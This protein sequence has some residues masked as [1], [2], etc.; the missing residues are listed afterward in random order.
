MYG[1]CF[2]VSS[3][4]ADEGKRK[5]LSYAN[6]EFDRLTGES[7]D[8]GTSVFS[9]SYNEEC[10]VDISISSEPPK[11]HYKLG[12]ETAE[13][14]SLLS[15]ASVP[16]QLSVVIEE[17]KT[18][19]KNSVPQN[20]VIVKSE[21]V[22]IECDSNA[23]LTFPRNDECAV[24][25][26][27]LLESKRPV[28]KSETDSG[29]DDCELYLKTYE[30][31]NDSKLNSSVFWERKRPGTEALVFSGTSGTEINM[32]TFSG[33]D[34]Q[35]S[36]NIKSRIDEHRFFYTENNGSGINPLSC[37]GINRPHRNLHVYGG[38][39]ESGISPS[40]Y[41]GPGINQSAYVGNS[42][43]GINSP[44]YTGNSGHG[45]NTASYPMYNRP[46]YTQPVCSGNNGLGINYLAFSGSDKSEIN[47]S[48]SGNNGVG[49]NS[50]T[51]SGSR[52]IMIP[53]TYCGNNG[54]AITPQTYSGNG[55]RVNL[56]SY[57]GNNGPGIN[58]QTYSGNNESGMNTVMYS[59]NS[60]PTINSSYCGSKGLYPVNTR[61][62]LNSPTY[63]GNNIS[64]I[65]SPSCS[66]NSG[67][68][69]NSPAYPGNNGPTVNSSAYSRNDGTGINSPT[70]SGNNG[71]G[72]NQMRFL[73]D[74]SF[75][76]SEV[77]QQYEILQSYCDDSESGTNNM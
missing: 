43:S 34:V 73:R 8:C 72:V 52:S 50:L 5:E 19:D 70:Y 7:N 41:S 9:D 44:A 33:N 20:C 45:I 32:P 64:G 77:A 29:N 42:G 18:T 6:K 47:P 61:D 65:N 36:G 15:R 38:S 30:G 16:K 39:T 69:I 57:S 59:S 63:T 14:D 35:T 1:V 40:V 58:A 21:V 10:Q 74:R 4:K 54:P 31:K 66:R 24:G 68:K 2:Q 22:T 55:S 76:W 67:L 11:K 26:L 23:L 75:G 51:Y 3:D 25:P 17:G 62:E 37:S 49:I 48:Y 60:G 13:C 71:S 12:K 53:R 46:G 56:L 28:I 27:S